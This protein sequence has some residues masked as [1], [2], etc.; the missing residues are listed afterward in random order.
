MDEKTRRRRRWLVRMWVA[1]AVLWVAS[2]VISIVV[3][4]GPT[5]PV[6]VINWILGGI[7][8]A[9]GLVTAWQIRREDTTSD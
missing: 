4:G 7:V 9:I 6:V 8:V 1:F 5:S 3:F 2:I